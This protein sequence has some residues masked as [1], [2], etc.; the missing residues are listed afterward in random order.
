MPGHSLQVDPVEDVNRD[1]SF[2]V[3][4]DKR[5]KESLTNIG[6]KKFAYE[7]GFFLG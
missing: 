7:T 1:G 5:T 3:K 2:R 6:I 4:K